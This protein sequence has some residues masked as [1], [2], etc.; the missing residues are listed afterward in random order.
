MTRLA[1]TCACPPLPIA[2]LAGPRAIVF[3]D[4]DMLALGP[5]GFIHDELRAE[6]RANASWCVHGSA[7]FFGISG[8]LFQAETTPTVPWY[9]NCGMLAFRTPADGGFLR[10]MEGRID[11]RIREDVHT[12]SADQDLINAALDARPS[13]RRVHRSWYA[14]YR[15]N[16]ELTLA[17]WKAV[18][19]MGVMKPWAEVGH[20][21]APV[22]YN[23]GYIRELD[24]MWSHECELAVAAMPAHLGADRLLPLCRRD[25][26]RVIPGRLPPSAYYLLLSALALAGLAWRAFGACRRSRLG[27]GGAF[28]CVGVCVG[29]WALGAYLVADWD[30]AASLRMMIGMAPRVMKHSA[31]TKVGHTTYE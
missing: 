6:G 22:R 23:D 26:H 4:L 15:P 25:L 28:G 9:I 17:T 1:R 5:L 19:W 8:W 12:F 31:L 2:R 20:T 14:N 21:T 10:R 30:H 24:A 16:T 29:V 18:H 27:L 11:Q 3:V 13:Q 7:N